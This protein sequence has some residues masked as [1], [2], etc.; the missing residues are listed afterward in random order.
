MLILVK[1]SKYW[2]DRWGKIEVLENGIRYK[3]KF[4]KLDNPTIKILE[5]L[6]SSKKVN[7]S[8]ILGLVEKE[9]FSK[10]HNERLKLQKI[11]EINF[12]LKTLIEVD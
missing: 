8:L 5:L 4:V 11:N 12:K 10:A 2:L 6:I 9:H 1:I 7:S 3:R